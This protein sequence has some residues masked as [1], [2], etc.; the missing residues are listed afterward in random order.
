MFDYF[1]SLGW[2]CGTADF[3]LRGNLE[4]ICE[5]QNNF[6]EVKY[7]LYFNHDI[8]RS[9]LRLVLSRL[10]EAKKSYSR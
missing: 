10:Y 2:F 8:E 1:I 5:K 4:E 9:K 3:L 7:N 6:K